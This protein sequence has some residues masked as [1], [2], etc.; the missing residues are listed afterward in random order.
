MTGTIARRCGGRSAATWIAVKPPYEMPHIP[1]AAVAPRLRGEPLDRV[2]AVAGLL[3]GVLV[4]RDAAGRPGPA[5]VDAG[6]ARSRA[7]RTTR[8]G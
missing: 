8:R 1:T 3:G 2:V 4:E 6:T 7:P 5:D